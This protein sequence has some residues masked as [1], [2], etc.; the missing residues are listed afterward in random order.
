[1]DRQ[2]ERELIRSAAAGD[3]AAAAQLI[4][5]H[6]RSVYAYILRM[7]GRPDIAEDIVQEAFVR[8]L[9]NLHKFDE[10]FRFS[11]WLFTIARRLYLNYAQ[12]MKP[13]YDSDTVGAA[14]GPAPEP[15]LAAERA[16]AEAVSRDALSRG[17]ATLSDEQREAVVLF[18]QQSWSI[19]VIA[20]HMGIPEGTV[21]SHLHRGRRR[22]RDALMQQE[23][24]SPDRL[25]AMGAP[26]PAD[27]PNP[28][29]E[30]PPRSRQHTPVDR[31]PVVPAPDAPP[32][33][34]A[35]SNRGLA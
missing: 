6:Q 19:A 20:Q 5:H 23:S 18:H 32:S 14:G 10:R 1:M 31:A 26:V 28:T 27:H 4:G 34:R 11:T 15:R 33:A 9:T 12:K 21:K 16:E 25:A 7:A 35:Q 17:L 29:S 30:A 24:G 3:R 22:L 8:V 2:S 13:A